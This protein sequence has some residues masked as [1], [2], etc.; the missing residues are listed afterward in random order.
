MQHRHLNHQRFTLAGIDD[1]ICRGR[2]QDWAE[3][4]Y[5]ILNDRSLLDKIEQV[6]RPHLV[7]PYAQRYHFWINYVEE[8]RTC[9]PA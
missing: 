5:A 9:D 8:R 7:D 4:R 2:R 3:L 1:L 6:C